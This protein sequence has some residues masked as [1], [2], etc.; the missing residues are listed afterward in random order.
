[1]LRFVSFHAPVL[2]ANHSRIA[3]VLVAWFV[4]ACDVCELLSVEFCTFVFW[5]NLQAWL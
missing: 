2:P 3:L 4:P 5:A 1:M